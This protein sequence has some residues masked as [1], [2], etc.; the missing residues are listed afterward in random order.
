MSLYNGGDLHS[1]SS[2]SEAGTPKSP[3]FLLPTTSSQTFHKKRKRQP[4][5][6]RRSKKDDIVWDRSDA[7]KAEYSS[8]LWFEKY[9]P[10]SEKDLAVTPA[11]VRAVKDWITESLRTN[12]QNGNKL[13]IIS[14]PSGCGKSTTVRTLARAMAFDIHEWMPFGPTTKWSDLADKQGERKKVI[15]IDDIPDLSNES[16]RQRFHSFIRGICKKSDTHVSVILMLTTIEESR[17]DEPAQGYKRHTYDFSERGVIPADILRSAFCTKIQYTPITPK[18]LTKILSSIYKCE[19]LDRSIDFEAI[20][21]VSNGDIR[22][23]IN[24]LQF[25]AIPKQ[26]NDNTGHVEASTMSREASLDLFH[27]IGKVLY[28]KRT[29]KGILESNPED[30]LASLCVPEQTF[31]LWLH[32]N[33]PPFMED[34]DS[35]ANA[36]E[37]L[38]LA[39]HLASFGEGYNGTHYESLLSVRGMMHSRRLP[40]SYHPVNKPEFW[41]FMGSKPDLATTPRSS[42]LHASLD[43]ASILYTNASEEDDEDIVEI[44]SDEEADE[45]MWGDLDD[46][47]LAALPDSQNPGSGMEI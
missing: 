20:A 10:K 26:H 22:S 28:A 37:Y 12:T 34:M 2:S 31:I 46:D 19:A 27:A 7:G 11:K 15:L 6:T 21:A 32:Q 17:G 25:Y 14:G 42:V 8:S 38:S 40:A 1:P 24:N 39:N 16:S 18:K 4:S 45:D 35:C 44:W 3:R 13:L 5:P 9:I 29:S 47:L 41:E 30:I 43:C 23:A 33:Y 36:V